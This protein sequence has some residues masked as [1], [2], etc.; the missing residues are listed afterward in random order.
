M[1]NG[2]TLEEKIIVPSGELIYEDKNIREKGLN[3]T[4]RIIVD[5]SGELKK[6]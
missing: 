5:V 4:I 1:E 2:K 3:L 6:S